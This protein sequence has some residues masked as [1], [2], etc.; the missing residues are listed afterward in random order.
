M[1]EKVGFALE[2]HYTHHYFYFDEANH[3]AEQGWIAF[4]AGDYRET[5]ACYTRVFP[6]WDVDCFG[7]VPDYLYLLAARARAALGERGLN[8]SLPRSTAGWADVEDLRAIP[9]FVPLHD[10]PGWEALLA[11][12][13]EAVDD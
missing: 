9:E 10:A 6:L 7:P 2:R 13:E 8:S 5:V 11:R 1:A 12:W 4:Q 3:L